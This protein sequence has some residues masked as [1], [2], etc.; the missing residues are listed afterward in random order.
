MPQYDK[1]IKEF[2]EANK[3]KESREC[4]A[5]VSQSYE[6]FLEILKSQ[7]VDCHRNRQ[8]NEYD[9]KNLFP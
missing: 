8:H 9:N 4:N 1:E 7:E 2:V 5:K 6:C 3:D